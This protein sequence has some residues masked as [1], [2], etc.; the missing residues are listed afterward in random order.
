MPASR[1][2]TALV[3]SRDPQSKQHSWDL[4]YRR[5]KEKLS[6]AE[7]TMRSSPS[8]RDWILLSAINRSE[9]QRLVLSY[10]IACQWKQHLA[11]RALALLEKEEERVKGLRELAARVVA[12]GTN[13]D[14]SS[15]MSVVANQSAT[16]PPASSGSTSATL[17]MAAQ[18]STSATSNAPADVGA[19]MGGGSGTTPMVASAIR[20]DIS[21]YRVHHAVGVGRT[22]GEGIEKTWAVLNPISYSTK[23]MGKGHRHDTI[24]GKI[25]HI[26]FMKNVAEDDTLARKYLIALAARDV[27]IAEFKEVN[28]SLEP[29][30]RRDWRRMV[31]V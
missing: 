25:D 19:G 22:D 31:D 1:L 17:D 23:E 11:A 9:V 15:D 10:D 14:V 2:K 26:N 27:Q 13:S 20:T 7:P 24:E 28:A 4:E 3:H 30:M 12:E 21:K 5:R 6:C 8:A 18:V 29:W 16:E